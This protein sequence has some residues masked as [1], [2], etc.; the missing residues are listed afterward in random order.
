MKRD[1]IGHFGFLVLGQESKE[2]FTKSRG[3]GRQEEIM[4]LV[5]SWRPLRI[6]KLPPVSCLAVSVMSGKML[7]NWSN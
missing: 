3:S 6:Q 2:A 7:L 5:P 1:F 4:Y